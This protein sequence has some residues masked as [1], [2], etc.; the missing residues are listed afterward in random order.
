MTIEHLHS[1]ILSDFLISSDFLTAQEK[2]M[3]R[4]HTDSFAEMFSLV[5][6]VGIWIS[7]IKTFI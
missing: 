3:I 4:I 2:T 7:P 6:W 1:D 5:M